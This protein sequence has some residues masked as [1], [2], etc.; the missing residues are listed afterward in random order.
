MVIIS[1]EEVVSVM[2]QIMAYCTMDEPSRVTVW[3]ERKRVMSF[4]Q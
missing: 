1:P 2:Y 3:A 4:F